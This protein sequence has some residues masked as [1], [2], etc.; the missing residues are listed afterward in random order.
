MNNT[1]TL[2]EVLM[3]IAALWNAAIF[4][5][6]G[7]DKSKARRGKRRISEAALIIPSFFGGSVGAMLGMIVFNHKTSKIKFRILIPLAF[8]VN[9]AEAILAINLLA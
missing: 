6:Y 7:A 9:I 8:S 1:F 3:I 2:P 4:I 5:L